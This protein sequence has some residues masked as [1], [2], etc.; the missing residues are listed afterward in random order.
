[1][2]TEPRRHTPIVL[3]EAIVALLEAARATSGEANAAL[4]IA[5][6]VIKHELVFT[7]RDDVAYDAE[8]AVRDAAREA[9]TASSS[10]RPQQP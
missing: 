9:A 2:S 8:R 1:M 4:A 10:R 6:Q 3:A 5:E 7:L